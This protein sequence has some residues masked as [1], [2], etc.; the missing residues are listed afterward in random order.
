ME[1][2]LGGVLPEGREETAFAGIDFK[3]EPVLAVF[4]VEIDVAAGEICD[5]ERWP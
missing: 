4:I 2:R 3:T 5:P 1:S